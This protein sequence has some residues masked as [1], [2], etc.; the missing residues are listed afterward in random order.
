MRNL[1]V[2]LAI[3]AGLIGALLALCLRV[4]GLHRATVALMMVLVIVGLARIWGSL[5][6]LVAALIGGIAFDYYFL[7]P[8]GFSIRT[9]ED[10]LDVTAFVVTAVVTGQLVGRLKRRRMEAEARKI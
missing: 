8:R 9:V 7:P 6:A 2:R 3:C 10:L 1:I 5:E 4:P